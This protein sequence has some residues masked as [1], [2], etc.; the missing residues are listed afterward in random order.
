MPLWM[1][2]AGVEAYGQSTSGYK[3]IVC[4][5]LVGGN[6]GNNMI[7]PLDTATYNQ[8]ASVRQSLALSQGSLL[9]VQTSSGKTYGFHPSLPNLSSIFSS[10]N[11]S[12]IANC[13]PM[14]QPVTKQALQ[15]NPSLLPQ[16][17][18]SHPVG[19]AQWESATAESAPSSGW[20]GR[21]ADQ[22]ASQSGL[23]PPVLSLSGVSTFTVGESVQS[24]SMMQASAGD[25]PL[26]PELLDPTISIA[27]IDSQSNNEIVQ[28]AAQLRS[29]ALQMQ[30]ILQQSQTLG[31][32]IKTVF[33]T[34]TLGQNLQTI[35]QVING[36][37]A[38]EAS[39]QLFY[40]NV[41][42][43][44]THGG[45]SSTHATLLSDLDSS[46]GAFVAALKEI[47]MFQNVLILT[48]SDF[49]RTMQSNSTAGS[50]HAWGNHQFLIGGGLS[51]N[52]IIG[53]LPDFDIGGSQDYTGQGVWIPTIATQ[54]VAANVATWLGLNSSQIANIFP[55]LASFS[56]TPISF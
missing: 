35:A 21:I 53:S 45:Q 51:G 8:Y 13:G 25:Q 52:R 47:G 56:A 20:G 34:S 27:N 5:S 46:L 31:S 55:N 11:A 44:D 22:I 6:D 40:A 3:A 38:T 14:D 50:D 32:T 18:G 29:S 7:V 39:R 48:L 36:R 30:T 15:Q 54:Q 28:R 43:Y 16:L 37:S 12:I 19:L 49:G 9:P 24:V 23:L 42:N 17:F 4:I 33:P 2:L 1:R 26:P 41:G 10:G